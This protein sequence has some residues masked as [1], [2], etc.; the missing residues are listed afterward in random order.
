MLSDSL[1]SR[2]VTLQEKSVPADKPAMPPMTYRQATSILNELDTLSYTKFK[3]FTERDL[4]REKA[5]LEGQ[6]MQNT[7]LS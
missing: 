6:F 5:T 2:A 1:K 7:R 4:L 3:L